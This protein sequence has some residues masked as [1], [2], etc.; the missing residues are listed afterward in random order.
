M[1]YLT[2]AF[3]TVTPYLLW[4]EKAIEPQFESKP[5]AEIHRMLADAM[6]YGEFFDFTDDEYLN[7][8]LSTP[9]GLENGV[10]IDKVRE[11]NYLRCTNDPTIAYEG[12]QVR[13]ATGR[14]MFTAR[15]PSPITSWAR[16]W[17]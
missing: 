12:R 1:R 11:K 7:I 13:T 14:A 15:T 2:C 4:N 10:T 5:D 17:I 9:W 3:A 8:V 16:R 6:G